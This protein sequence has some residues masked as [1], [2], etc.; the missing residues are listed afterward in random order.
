MHSPVNRKP[1][2]VFRFRLADQCSEWSR[3]RKIRIFKHSHLPIGFAA[4]CLLQPCLDDPWLTRRD[5]KMHK[6]RAMLDALMGPGRNQLV[7]DEENAKEKF[8]DATVC[9]AYLVGCC[10]LDASLLGG[11]RKFAVCE[12]IHSDMMKEQLNKHPD[13]EQLKREYEKMLLRDLDFVIRECEAHIALENN[14]VREDVRRKKPPLP[15]QV[16]DRLAQ[17]KRESSALI[18]RAEA[19]DDDKLKE[20]EALTQQAN[21]VLKEREEVLEEETKKAIAALPPHDICEAPDQPFAVP[22]T[23]RSPEW[24]WLEYL[25]H[26]SCSTYRI[27]LRSACSVANKRL[28]LEFDARCK[29]LLQL[30]AWLPVAEIPF[31]QTVEDICRNGFK[32]GHVGVS[33]HV[34][35]LQLPSLYDDGRDRGGNDRGHNVKSRGRSLPAGRRLYEFLLCRVGAGRSYLVDKAA[36]AES[37]ALPP[38]FDSFCVRHSPANEQVVNE[39]FPGVLPRHVLHHEYMV[40]D[41]AQALPV[42]LVHFEFDPEMPELLNLPLCDSCGLQAAL[43]YCQADDAILCRPCDTRIHSANKLA[44]RHIRVELNRF[45]PLLFFTMMLQLG[46]ARATALGS[47][48]VRADRG[49]DLEGQALKPRLDK[50]PTIR[51][52]LA[53][54]LF[55]GFFVLGRSKCCRSKSGVVVR[56][57]TGRTELLVD[58]DARSID[59]IRQ[60]LNLLKEKGCQVQATIFAS[61]GRITNKKWRQFMEESCIVFEPV[62]R[63]SDETSE[64]NDSAIEKA[65]RTFLGEDDV[66]CVGLLTADKG[67]IDVVAELESSGSRTVVLIPD[68]MPSVILEYAKAGINVLKLPVK[69]QLGGHVR[70]VLHS[71]GDGSVHQTDPFE[72]FDCTAETDR[73]TAFLQDLGF[74]GH[75]GYLIQAAAKFWFSNRLG[76]L[77]VYP[78]QLA[79]M[80]V[81]DVIQENSV[82]SEP[83]NRDQDLAFVLPVSSVGSITKKGLQAYGSRGS[84]QVLRGG[85]PFILHD[86]PDLIE[87]VLRRLGYLD[88]HLNCDFAEALFCFLNTSANKSSLRKIGLLPVSGSRSCDVCANLRAAFLSNASSGRWRKNRGDETFDSL[89]LKLR[90]AKVVEEDESL[91]AP[92]EV[93][94]AMKMYVKRQGLP[95]MQTFNGNAWRILQTLQRNPDKRTECKLP[96]C[97]HCRKLG[98]H[99]AGEAK[100]HRLIG[101]REAYQHA[102]K[103]S[104]STANSMLSERQRVE[105]QQVAQLDQRLVAVQESTQALEDGIYDQVQSAVK[106]GQALAEEQASL[107]MADELE[108]KRQLDQV[109]WMD[110]FME[111]HVKNLPPP[112][113]LN[114]WLLHAKVREEVNQLGR[115]QQARASAMLRLEG[116]LRLVTDDS[117]VYP[118]EA[119]GT[120]TAAP[121]PRGSPEKNVC[122]TSYEGDAGNAAHKKFRIHEA[123]TIVRQRMD[124]LKPRVEEWEKAQKEK[125]GDT[126]EKK[127]EKKSERRKDRENGKHEEKSRARDKERSRRKE[128]RSRSRHRNSRREKSDRRRHRQSRSPSRRRS[129]DSECK[130]AF[131]TVQSD[132]DTMPKASAALIFLHGSGDTGPG[133]QAWLNDVSDRAF[134]A[135]LKAKGIEVHFPTAPSVPY[136]LIGG[137]PQTVWFDRVAMAYDAPEDDR[138][139]ESGIAVSKIGVAGMSMGGCLAL[140]VGY[141]MGRHAG[142]LGMVASLSTFLPKESCLDSS[143][144]KGAPL[145]MAHGGSPQTTFW[146]FLQGMILL[147]W[148]Q[149]THKRLLAAGVA[150]EELRVF[151]GV[152]HAL[153]GEE[154]NELQTFVAVAG[155]VTEVENVSLGCGT[156]SVCE[157]KV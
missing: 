115:L 99:S 138:L 59:E 38:E 54:I 156:F 6:T 109:A 19:L 114:A 28:S 73:V 77:T 119:A 18:Q 31:G 69:S 106:Q 128:S 29:G 154:V 90:Q 10:P 63:G 91:P 148:A 16:N 33:F 107:F 84:R 17:M 72:V 43:V 57:A 121:R 137:M 1:E 74:M 26:A 80:S 126:A 116:G 102:L 157:S 129:Q 70:A 134:E 2:P 100:N 46:T 23:R 149:A 117:K 55:A 110:S 151:P 20:K 87:Q 53:H 5:A 155:D 3:T 122:G 78:T 147:P 96:V 44:S 39:E 82:I 40:R 75:S 12:K 136:S 50:Q 32:A 15:I 52:V 34:G 124:E 21:E 125:L 135:E 41:P 141:G 142:K 123:Y 79:T 150:A 58:A 48:L 42:Y 93:L 88:D 36:Q 35:N 92:A 131:V 37:L 152:Q 81:L 7:K 89:V 83:Y 113:Y 153:C 64:P 22:V 25:L 86:S 66:A 101:L 143:A 105:Q 14:R 145:F 49:R 132:G 112:D 85:G 133:V 108:A 65:M 144:T 56:G 68:S 130:S 94:E 13:A 51:N 97:Q 127:E 30:H 4:A 76:S 67:F 9:K 71:N 95:A 118:S 103:E 120:M 146:T 140:H 47:S 139:I 104:S 11:K 98:N 8:K 62:L 27:R 45:L 60:A 24:G 111:D 61:P